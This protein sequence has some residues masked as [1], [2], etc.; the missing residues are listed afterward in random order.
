[1]LT[2][3]NGKKFD[4]ANISLVDCVRGNAMDAHFT[5]KVFNVL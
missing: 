1:M 4:W 5:L 2:V 3:R